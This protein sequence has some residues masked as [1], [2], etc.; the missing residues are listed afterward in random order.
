[1]EP[2]HHA[3]DVSV[4]TS[5]YE[6]FGNS[7]CEAMACGKPVVA[8]RGGSVEEVLG[9]AGAIVDVGNLEGLTQAAQRFVEDGTRRSTVGANARQRVLAEFSPAKSYQIVSQLYSNLASPRGTVKSEGVLS[10][11]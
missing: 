2:F 11:A 8:Y 5:E 6:T 3:C 4:S 7:V 1:V 9:D 10:R